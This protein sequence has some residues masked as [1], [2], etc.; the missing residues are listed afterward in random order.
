MMGN[1]KLLDHEYLSPQELAGF[2]T[3]KYSS[4]DSSPIG[5]YITHP[6]WNFV[7]KFCP[8]WIA[9][10]VLTFSGFLL[11]V[12]NFVMF[13]YYDPNFYASSPN[14]P[15]LPI[16]SW[17]F[18]LAA[19]NLFLAHTLDGIDGKQARR[20]GTSGPLGELFDHGLDSWSSAFIPICLYSA[21]GCADLTTFRMFF[22]MWNVFFNFYTSHWEKYNTGV[23]FLP[24][25]Y[26]GA[27]IVVIF[28]FTITGIFGHEMWYFSLWNGFTASH[29]FEFLFYFSALITN[30]PVV[31]WNIYLSYRDRTGRMRPLIEAVR[32]LFPISIL[33]AISTVWV[34]WS[35]NNIVASD[36]RIV[37]LMVGT[38]FSNICCRLI[39]AQMSDQRCDAFNLLLVPLSAVVGCVW[40][41]PAGRSLMLEQGLLY[42]LTAFA[43]CAHTHYGTCV[44]RQMC[45]H[46]RIDCFR[47]RPHSE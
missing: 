21:F 4:I 47:I 38:I 31:L 11:T 19:V 2:E 41:L 10:N 36:G 9:P 40:L 30:V 43:I 28:L 44:V 15:D 35:P 22:C 3:Y 23:L 34:I 25:G 17:V 13:A 20:T 37:F 29:L 33:M 45:R 12:V 6:F 18:L 32:P 5:K 27:M 39:V 46:F 14:K 1:F 26:D 7:V 8:T 24:W 42:L 16:P